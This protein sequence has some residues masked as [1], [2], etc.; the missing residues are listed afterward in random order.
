MR[1]HRVKMV[2]AGAT[3]VWCAAPLAV[4]AAPVAGAVARA[5]TWRTAIEVPG[6]GSLNRGGYAEVHSVSCASA[7]NCAAGGVFK[8]RSRHLQGFGGSEKKGSGGE[9]GRGPGWGGGKRG[10]QPARPPG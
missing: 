3:A 6:L 7:G 8:D 5:G 1:R 9:L 2:L 10:G 4:S